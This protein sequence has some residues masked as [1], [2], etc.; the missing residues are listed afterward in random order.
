MRYINT[1]FTL[2]VLSLPAQAP[3]QLNELESFLSALDEKKDSLTI[4][5][6]HLVSAMDSLSSRIDS[7]K[8]ISGATVATG[9]LQLDLRE[10][11]I[12]SQELENLETRLDSFDVLR[13]RV[14]LQLQGAY[15]GE[16]E[17]LVKQLSSGVDSEVI[18][19]LAVLQAR[20]EQLFSRRIGAKEASVPKLVIRADDGPDE[21]E[22][23]VE[24]L[25][26]MAKRVVQDTEKTGKQL[27]RLMEEKRLRSRLSTFTGQL[28][29]FDEALAE[30]RGVAPG[31]SLQGD[32]GG[33]L[34]EGSG[35]EADR[36]SEGITGLAPPTTE[37]APSREEIVTGREISRSGSELRPESIASGDLSVE[38]ARLKARQSDLEKRRIELLEQLDRF[39]IRL[40]EM[41]EDLN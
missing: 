5:R 6:S 18:N 37:T 41:V 34:T 28:D 21:L 31:G 11:L 4:Q 12:I 9:V 26:D 3:A 16:I 17:F 38:I 22:Q 32:E 39:R 36:E 19:R 33:T 24:L 35:F 29:L 23:K 15:D 8:A 27:S 7:L 10:S 40:K 30:G 13:N 1:I 20:K 25:S 2:I 14:G